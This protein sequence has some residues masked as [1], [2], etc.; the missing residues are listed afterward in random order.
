MSQIEE[1]SNLFW[2]KSNAMNIGYVLNV[3]KS[4]LSGPS[5]MGFSFISIVVKV[6]SHHFCGF[7]WFLQKLLPW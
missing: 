7:K 1:I 5:G 4:V 3:T 6:Y 2:L